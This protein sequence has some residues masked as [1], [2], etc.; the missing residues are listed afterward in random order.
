MEI[1][2]S[3]YLLGLHFLLVGSA[4]IA[5]YYAALRG[6][7]SL[8]LYGLLLVLSA[9]LYR[10]YV[11]QGLHKLRYL[12]LGDG[13][14]YLVHSPG[15]AP[16][17]GQLYSSARTIYSSELLLILK[18][19]PGSY[20]ASGSAYLLLFPDSLKPE[21]DHRLRIHLADLER[22]RIRRGVV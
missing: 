20:D 6:V 17:R 21:D 8:G 10:D 16:W 12:Q 13:D 11:Q 14:Y 15:T 2:S 9:A 7:V 18:L 3:R 19:V 1:S 22:D 4:A 5:I